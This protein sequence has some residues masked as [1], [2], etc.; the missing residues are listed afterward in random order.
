MLHPKVDGF[1]NLTRLPPE[2]DYMAPF[3]YAEHKDLNGDGTLEIEKFANDCE[4]DCAGG[5][6]TSQIYRWTGSGY[7]P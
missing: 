2:G 1:D 7:R 5:T 4:P 3:Y 6:I